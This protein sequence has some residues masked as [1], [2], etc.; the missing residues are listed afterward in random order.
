M[1]SGIPAPSAQESFSDLRG[2]VVTG[3]HQ[4]GLEGDIALDD[5]FGGL[6]ADGDPGDDRQLAGL[7]GT[8]FN[9]NNAGIYD[10]GSGILG[11]WLGGRSTYSRNYPML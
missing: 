3:D 2:Q 1:R 7:G 11:S 6:L 10:T 9:S 4:V 8:E 5:L